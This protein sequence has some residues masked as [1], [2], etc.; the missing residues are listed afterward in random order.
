MSALIPIGTDGGASITE[1]PSLLKRW[2]NIQEEMATLNNEVKQRRTQSKALREVIL[3]IMETNRVVKLNV[4]KGAVVH[5][6]REVAE[7]ISNSYMLKHCKDFF[8]GDEEK[9]KALVA[10]LESN[11]NTTVKHEL[12]LHAPSAGGSD[13]DSPA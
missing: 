7:K 5:K 4:S 2:M 6:T 12:K 3:R 1:L 10:Y 9:A 8:Q 13:E 11:R